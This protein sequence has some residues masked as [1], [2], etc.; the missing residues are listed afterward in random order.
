MNLSFPA[1]IPRLLRGQL[2][3]SADGGLFLKTTKGFFP[4][5]LE[6]EPIPLGEEF[7]FKFLRHEPGRVV[8]TRLSQWEYWREALPFLTELPGT[9][10]EWQNLLQAAVRQGLPL[11]KEIL[12]SLRRWVLTAE[13]N[14]G[15]KVDPEVFA[16]LLSKNLPVTPGSILLTLY[17]L[18]PRVQKEVWLNAHAFPKETRNGR[19]EEI[20]GRLL[21]F[22]VS[23]L[24]K[25]AGK[26]ENGTGL[27]GFWTGLLRTTA[28]FLAGQA[29]QDEN[30]PQMVVCLSPEPEKTVRWEGRG[31][32]KGDRE[33]KGYSFR[34]TWRSQVLGRVEVTG[35]ERKE[36]VELLI[37][38]E[39]V[40]VK[41]QP[42]AW[43]SLQ[44]FKS[45]LE[46]KGWKVKQ[47][48][49]SKITDGEKTRARA[50]ESFMPPRVDGW[51]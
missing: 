27:R 23:A 43:K 5:K 31:P 15:V 48:V 37:A 8:M 40:L 35:V 49:F 45:Y 36:E 1:G 38:V 9:D 33:E 46:D 42:A 44:E 19:G 13:K 26:E 11:E 22:F 3:K 2:I 20:Q 39:E 51:V 34:L 4:V 14:W 32:A 21:S 29:R 12:L 10:A 50:A 7:A 17:L 6:G 24:A 47:V 16:F 30:L 18:F 41:T 25:A 28:K